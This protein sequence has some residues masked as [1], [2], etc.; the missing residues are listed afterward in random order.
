[1]FEQRDGSHFM[2]PF[3]VGAT[4]L[5]GGS[6]FV[7]LVSKGAVKSPDTGAE[8]YLAIMAAYAGAGELQKWKQQKADP[9]TLLPEDPW[10]ERARK[11]GFFVGFWLLLYAAA[12]LLRI[13]DAA[14]PMPHEL[15]SITLQVVALFFVTYSVRTLRRAKRGAVP[16]EDPGSPNLLVRF[17]ASRPQG[18]TI[19][20][21]EGQFP[22]FNRRS[23][24]RMIAQALEI[25]SLM[26]E[27]AFRSPEA[28][29]RA[30]PASKPSAN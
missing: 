27:G 28:R 21:I 18:A 16:D 2:M 19:R 20:E 1:M 25:G 30:S 7:E 14:Y 22:D 12:Y 4:A 23:L 5:F 11:G 6:A 10:L 17:V 15:K 9:E 24:N 8:I 26:R 3:A 29:Y 13:I